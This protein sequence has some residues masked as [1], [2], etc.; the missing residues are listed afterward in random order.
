MPVARRIGERRNRRKGPEM[1]CKCGNVLGR[2]D[3]FCSRCG[4]PVPADAGT[5]DG[6]DEAGEAEW[7]MCGYIV[8]E[9]EEKPNLKDRAKLLEKLKSL[10]SNGGPESR[11]WW[12]RMAG[13]LEEA[14][15][16]EGVRGCGEDGGKPEVRHQEK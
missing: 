14:A 7:P 8:S 3:R 11:D 2:H 12:K 13:R 9:E 4:A 6:G 15:D 1:K 10:T 5:A 16:A